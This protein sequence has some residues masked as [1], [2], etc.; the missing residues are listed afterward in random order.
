MSEEMEL[1]PVEELTQVQADAIFQSHQELL[2]GCEKPEV[3]VK[4]INEGIKNLNDIEKILSKEE[5]NEMKEKQI[6]A[7]ADIKAKDL[8]FQKWKAEKEFEVKEKEIQQRQKQAE[9]ELN[10][11]KEQAEEEKKSKKIDIIVKIL[12]CLIPIILT[13]IAT[14]IYI[15][16]TAKENRETLMVT[17]FANEVMERIGNISNVTP[18]D[19]TKEAFKE[20]CQKVNFK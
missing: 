8:E 1:T 10:F 17:L 6:K 4:N 14:V 16:V 12:I 7:D 13:S 3:R 19:V 5:D 15:K 18:K 11:K 9:D 20:A 2:E